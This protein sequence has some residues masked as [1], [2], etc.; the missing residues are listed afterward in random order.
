MHVLIIKFCIII[1]V[2]TIAGQDRLCYDYPVLK[3]NYDF[4]YDYS[5][6][7]L[8]S[9]LLRNFPCLALEVSIGEAV[10]LVELDVVHRTCNAMNLFI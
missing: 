5:I 9:L 4:G 2:C 1:L 7:L 8:K 10:S 3:D 6:F